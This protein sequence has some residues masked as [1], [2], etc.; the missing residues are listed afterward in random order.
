MSC[1]LEEVRFGIDKKVKSFT[2]RVV[3]QWLNRL[4]RELVDVLSLEV[5][6]VMLN[7]ILSNLMWLKGTLIT[8]EVGLDDL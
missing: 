1:K 8:A 2:V 5:F 3:K 7:G 4:P 6:K